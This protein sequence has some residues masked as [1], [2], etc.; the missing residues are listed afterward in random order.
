MKPEWGNL[1]FEEAIALFR[2]KT[3]VPTARWAE[4]WGA[5]HTRGFTVAG[6]MKA[7]LLMDLRG[8]V[9]AAIADGE[10]LGQFRKRFDSIV[11]RHGWQYKGPR[12]WRTDLIYATNI[13]TVHHA[14]RYRQQQRIKQRRPFWQY[15]HGESRQPRQQH[16]AWDGMILSADDPWWATHYPPNGWGCKCRVHSLGPRDLE[17]MGVD[18][19]DEAPAVERYEWTDL[20]T[21]ETKMIPVGIDPGWDFNPGQAAVDAWKPDMTEYPAT[22]ARA[23]SAEIA[24]A[25]AAGAAIAQEILN[26]LEGGEEI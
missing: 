17:R 19:P 4:L 15:R 24:E 1:P 9:D 3:N 2:R 12:K 20:A 25:S 16:L 23:L 26:S 8:A 14:G 5:A 10:S 22:L 21:G 18:G 11:D 13:R 6:A 7:D